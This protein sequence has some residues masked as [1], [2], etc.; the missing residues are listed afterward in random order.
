M[1]AILSG[2]QCVKQ[3]QSNPIIL[4]INIFSFLN[5]EIAQ[6]AEIFPDVR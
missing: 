1:S 3:T 5:A 6:V 4:T 2:P